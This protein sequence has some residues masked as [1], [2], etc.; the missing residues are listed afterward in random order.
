M[1]IRKQNAAK[2]TKIIK[3]RK[4]M[5]A[6]ET[7]TQIIMGAIKTHWKLGKD[8]MEMKILYELVSEKQIKPQQCLAII[9]ELDDKCIV[10]LQIDQTA[11]HKL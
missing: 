1:R 10:Y 3:R 9:K 7:S 6:P 4:S 5:P 11:I 8:E 2:T